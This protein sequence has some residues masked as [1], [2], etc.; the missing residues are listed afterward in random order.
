M[1]FILPNIWFIFLIAL[2]TSYLTFLTTKG[3]LTDNRNKKIWKRL[4]SRGKKVFFVL[5]TILLAL[6]AQ[7]WN[8]INSSNLKDS[9]LKKEQR[10][11]DSII[12]NK[13][14][15]ATDSINNKYYQNI[16]TAFSKQDL[17][18][19]TLNQTII[20]I[21][22]NTMINTNQQI[23][24][25]FYLD[26]KG[27]SLRLKTRILNKY[28]LEVTIKDA[29]ATNFKIDCRALTR[30]TNNHFSLSSINFFPEDMVIPKNGTWK[31]GFSSFTLTKNDLKA[32]NIYLNFTGTY[33]SIDGLKSYRINHI[34][35][36]D[37]IENKVSYPANYY[38]EEIQ[39]IMNKVPENGEV[40]KI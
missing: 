24:P 37:I 5:L 27:V 21:K 1:N 31:T 36:Y 22:K 40:V 11:R 33:T 26:S 19:D 14:A 7:E 18:L 23:S 20:K 15:Y 13:I 6:V 12:E 3:Q 8:N 32:T 39:E 2:L 34:Y 25:V 29:G 38:R 28:N 17:K 16:A 35:D 9:L 30:Y 10:L 4:T